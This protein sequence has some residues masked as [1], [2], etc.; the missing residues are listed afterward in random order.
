MRIEERIEHLEVCN[1]RIVKVQQRM[2]G[3]LAGVNK[4]VTVRDGDLVLVSRD[5]GLGTL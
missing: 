3:I 1:L 2:V 5:S 4:T